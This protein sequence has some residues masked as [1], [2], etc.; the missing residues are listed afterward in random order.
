MR[1]KIGKV[2]TTV[3]IKNLMD[4]SELNI[5]GLI[6]RHQTRDWG[7]LTQEDIDLNDEVI[8]NQQKDGRLFSAY[9][10]SDQ[11]RIYIITEDHQ[12]VDGYRFVTT[13]MLSEEY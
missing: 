10:A 2:F 1:I 8:K 4:S 7:D 12:G 9:Q 5:H 6:A 13:I 3:G 11:H